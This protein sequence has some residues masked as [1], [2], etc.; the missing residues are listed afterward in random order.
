MRRVR[1][2]LVLGVAILLAV[3]AAIVLIAMRQ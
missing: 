1:R 2:L 3:A